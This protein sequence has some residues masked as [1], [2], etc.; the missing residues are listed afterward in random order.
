[1]FNFN[2]SQ[3][4]LFFHPKTLNNQSYPQ[5]HLPCPSWPWVD[6]LNLVFHIMALYLNLVIHALLCFVYSLVS[7][8]NCVQFHQYVVLHHVCTSEYSDPYHWSCKSQLNIKHALG[9]RNF[10]ITMIQNHKTNLCITIP[11]QACTNPSKLTIIMHSLWN[12]SQIGACF[13]NQVRTCT[14]RRSNEWTYWNTSKNHEA[15]QS[16]TNLL[17]QTRTLQYHMVII[18]NNLQQQSCFCTTMKPSTPASDL[19]P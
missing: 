19:H 13:W 10:N 8:C 17:H 12:I 5:F 4:N 15:M 9:Q 3:P 16:A 6:H 18:S 1:M 7:S 11:K 2:Q 14:S